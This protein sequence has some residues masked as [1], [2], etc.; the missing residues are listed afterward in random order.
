MWVIGRL[1]QRIKR[2]TSSGRPNAPLSP[3]LSAPATVLEGSQGRLSY[4]QMK[5]QGMRQQCGW[6]SGAIYSW[7]WWSEHVRCGSGGRTG[8]VELKGRYWK[9]STGGD[10]LIDVTRSVLLKFQKERT[11]T[12]QQS[13]NQSDHVKRK[14]ER[15]RGR[16][17]RGCPP[18]TT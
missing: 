2:T 14:V 1:Y 17:Q 12:V 18:R 16:G 5:R 10:T 6:V 15:R 8:G 11:A 4:E 7:S 9:E 3:L 13:V